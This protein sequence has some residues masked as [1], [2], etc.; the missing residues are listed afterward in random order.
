MGVCF[1][2]IL[3]AQEGYIY[4]TE[5]AERVEYGNYDRYDEQHK[6]ASGQ[7]REVIK[8]GV[9]YDKRDHAKKVWFARPVVIVSTNVLQ[10]LRP[11]ENVPGAA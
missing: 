1:W 10:R 8:N 6:A 3:Q 9:C 7:T 2:L 5:L 11:R 4:F